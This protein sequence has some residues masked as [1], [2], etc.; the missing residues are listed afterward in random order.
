MQI[1]SSYLLG[2]KV[3]FLE[4][5][6][7]YYRKEKVAE[8]QYAIVYV[9]TT[10]EHEANQ[11]F[12]IWKNKETIDERLWCSIQY[13]NLTYRVYCNIIIMHTMVGTQKEEIWK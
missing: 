13:Y 9:K 2:D 3:S 6:G 12:W 5:G 4:F 8:I 11:W 10:V 1:Y 7:G